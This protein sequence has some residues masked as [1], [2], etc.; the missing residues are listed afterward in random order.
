[1]AKKNI[2]SVN[3]GI[4]VSETFMQAH[5]DTVQNVVNAIVEAIR[6]EKS[7]RAFAETEMTK[8][9][10]LTDKAALDFTY[11]FYINEVLALGP[12]PQAAQVQSNIDA[13]AAKNPKVKDLNA[14]SMI[15]QSFVSGAEQARQ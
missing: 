8:N 5:R 7:D 15:D 6:R 4:W 3:A 10:G 9:L 1:L 13:L 14:A 12:K 2:P 11:D